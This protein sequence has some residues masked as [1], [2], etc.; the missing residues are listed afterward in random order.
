ML[1]M[2][3]FYRVTVS[4]FSDSYQV[5]FFFQPKDKTCNYPHGLPPHKSVCIVR[6]M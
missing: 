4:P 2:K 5:S 1:I 3:Y 6:L